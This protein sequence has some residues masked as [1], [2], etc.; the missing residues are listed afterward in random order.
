MPTKKGYTVI[1]DQNGR[2]QTSANYKTLTEARSEAREHIRFIAIHCTS[3][4]GYKKVGD[5]I[6]DNQLTI[7]HAAF[8]RE[9]GAYIQKRMYSAHNGFYTVP[10]NEYNY[11]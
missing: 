10:V 6:R 2:E 11:D 5:L 9:G 1:F 4:R 8:G 3:K 7:E